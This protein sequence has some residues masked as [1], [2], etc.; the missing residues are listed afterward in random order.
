VPKADNNTAAGR[1]VNRRVELKVL[2]PEVLREYN[3]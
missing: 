1:E 3:P 2:N